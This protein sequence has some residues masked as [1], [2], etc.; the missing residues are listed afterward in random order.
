[1]LIT[2]NWEPTTKNCNPHWSEDNQT[3]SQVGV[4]KKKKKN[5]VSD[6][7]PKA[8]EIS[9]VFFGVTALV[10]F[11]TL[12]HSVR[13]SQSLLGGRHM[14]WAG[15]SPWLSPSWSA[16]CS[17]PGWVGV[18]TKI[19]AELYSPIW[20]PAPKATRC[21]GRAFYL[22]TKVPARSAAVLTP[23]GR[24]GSRSVL[25]NMRESMPEAKVN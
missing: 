6:W 3:L 10:S 20:L 21:G 5:Q 4:K 9:L 17:V 11:T 12:T 15:P 23:V 8:T 13:K 1:M 16:W 18:R 7:L 14:T 19:Q 24:Q 22:C 25:G 2:C